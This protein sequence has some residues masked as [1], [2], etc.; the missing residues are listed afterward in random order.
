VIIAQISDPHIFHSAGK[1][2]P[3][4][5]AGLQRAVAHL[6]S[7]PGTPDVVLLTGDCAHRGQPI[8]Y[9]RVRELVSALKAPAYVIPGNH[10]DRASLRESFGSQGVE[11]L[12]GFVQFVVDG[13]PVRL[14]AL[15]T[16]LPGR[17]EG[18]LSTAQLDWLDARLAERRE[19]PALIFMHHP[20]FLT[21]IPVYDD[22]GLLDAEAFGA[23]IDRHPQVEAIVAGHL[24]ATMTRRFHGT[25]AMTCA[26]TNHQM[27]PDLTAEKVLAAVMEPA[28][29]LVHEWREQTGLHT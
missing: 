21:G 24:H 4:G 5:E 8:E 12:D 29:C 16:S 26:S 27:L 20:P 1:F 19:Q 17:D 3:R 6:N 25:V 13:H 23:V 15:D 18:G 9:E 28:A 7:L 11:P 10:D 14:I 2:E 22:I